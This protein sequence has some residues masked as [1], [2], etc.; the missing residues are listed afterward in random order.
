MKRI[1]FFVS[2]STGITAETMAQ[3]LLSQFREI[4]FKSV[5]MPYTDTV[6]KAL[7]LNEQ[8]AE[9]IKTTGYRPLVFG[10][11][12]DEKIRNVLEQ[13]PC[14]YIEL[15]N[16]FIDRLSEELGIQPTRKVGQSHALA[17]DGSYEARMHAI[18]FTM[19]TDDGMKLDHYDSA[20]IILIG[21]S[22][23]GKT[24][25]CLYLAMHFG[26]CAANY[27]LTDDDFNRS[28]LPEQLLQNKHKLF[29]LYIEPGRLR[30]IR[31]ERRPGSSY[32]SLPQC[33]QETRQAWHIF[34]RLNVRVMD[35]SCHSIEEIASQIIKI[36]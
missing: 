7:E 29:G 5:Y 28:G 20:D 4:Q 3:S 24:P 11:M 2:E 36:M 1:V 32:A 17:S 12:I 27:P 16:V 21:L 33:E 25:T 13:G 10:T 26:V 15:Y 9:V 22:R 30:R 8:F 14:C 35:T 34:K 31:E 6:D 18:N 23:S 19:A